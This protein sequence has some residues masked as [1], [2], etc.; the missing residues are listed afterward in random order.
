MQ[1]FVVVVFIK[2][3]GAASVTQQDQAAELLMYGPI[4]LAEDYFTL[5]SIA[6]YLVLGFVELKSY[7]RRV[8]ENVSDSTCP[9]FSWLLRIFVLSSILGIFLL[10]NML[11]E[12]VFS[13]SDTTFFHWQVYFVYISFIIYYLGFAGYKQPELSIQPNLPEPALDDEKDLRKVSDSQFSQIIKALEIEFRDNKA[14]LNPTLSSLD[15]ARSLNVSQSALSF[16]INK[17]Y[18]KTFREVINELRVEEVKAKLMQYSVDGHSI[19]SIALDSGFNSEASF[20]R[21]FKKQEGLAP[22]AYIQK[23]EAI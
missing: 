1:F 16:A 19:L 6:W 12:M 9:T 2:V 21:I 15:L 23:I 13:L 8:N 7:R 5:L 20:Y 10:V 18:K 22:K 4:K 3:A 11:A 17:H 14:Y